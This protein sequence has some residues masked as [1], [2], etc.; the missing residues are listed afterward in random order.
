MAA[1]FIGASDIIDVE[2]PPVLIYGEASAGKTSLLQTGADDVLTCDFDEGVHRSFF[3]KATIRFESWADL[4]EVQKKGLKTNGKWAVAPGFANYSLVGLDTVGTA[5]E[6]LKRY[7]LP[8]NSTRGGQLT[9]TGWGIVKETFTTWVAQLRHDLKKQLVFVA[10]QRT[11]KSNEGGF[12]P[13]IAG[14]S[15]GIVMNSCDVVGYLFYRN[16]ER[17]LN[18]EPCDAW[19][20]K[21][22][23]RLESG[24]VPNFAEVPDFLARLLA[25]AKQNLGKTAEASAKVAAEVE[26]WQSWL[27]AQPNG[28]PRELESFNGALA[29][30]KAMT[31]QGKRQAWHLIEEYARGRAWVFEKKAKV[32]VE[33]PKPEATKE[34]GAA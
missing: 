22:G 31:P 29:D 16:N 4:L 15:Y 28:Q 3:R 1:T 20:A 21:N 2:R 24:T 32:F 6:C 23:A 12:E 30:L 34:A 7:V 33:A 10:H 19:Y 13:D 26:H 17:T 11:R 9:Q 25:Q 5:L 18:F 14:G 27:A 8:A